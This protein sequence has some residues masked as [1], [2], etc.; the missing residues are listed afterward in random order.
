M[1]YFA[2]NDQRSR[3]PLVVTDL[4]IENSYYAYWKDQMK[5]ARKE[6]LISFEAC[7]DDWI[8]CN[9]AWEVKGPDA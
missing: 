8:V 3:K 1:R 7:L 2:F 5:K 9:W 6:H 4:E